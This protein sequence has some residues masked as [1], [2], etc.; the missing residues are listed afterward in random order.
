MKIKFVAAVPV[1]FLFVLV[2]FTGHQGGSLT[3][4][5]DYLSVS[6]IKKST[7]RPESA[8]D[9]ILFEQIVLP[10]LEKKCISCHGRTKQKGGLTLLTVEQIIKGGASG[11]AVI[12]GNPNESELIKRISLDPGHED[13]MPAEGK[14][15]LTKSEAV[16][17]SWW[18]TEGEPMQ[19][20]KLSEY[21]NQHEIKNTIN[22][23]LG[24]VNPEKQASGPAI[25]LSAE[26]Y[27]IKQ[28]T[29]EALRKT[30]VMVRILQ[31]NPLMLD[32]TIPPGSDQDIKT[33]SSNIKS[34]KSDIIWLKLS[35]NNLRDT[36]LEFLASLIN[37]QKLRLEKNP[38]GDGISEHLKNLKNL[39]AVNLNE[40]KIT[41]AGLNKLRKNSGIKRIYYWHTAADHEK[42]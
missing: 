5:D 21:P 16:I 13:F 12:P 36:D 7:E 19:G 1:L 38:I 31:H 10:I 20:K 40:T 2:L 28:G 25:D 15:P 3:H 34:I 6:K 4:G 27:K 42:P 17:L 8:E 11:P 37:L 29:I 39:E 30:G 35:E 18:I 26:T 9:A 32:V 33:F 23:Y 41:K 14:T 22:E 24:Y